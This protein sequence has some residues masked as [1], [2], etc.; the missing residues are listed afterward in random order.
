MRGQ[1]GRQVRS[2]TRELGLRSG[3][4]R[5]YRDYPKV[6]EEAFASNG[7]RELPRRP[8]VYSPEGRQPSIPGV[9]RSMRTSSWIAGLAAATLLP[10]LAQA[11][12]T[13]EQNHG[14][15][16]VGT[17]AGAGAGALLGSA[18]AGHDNRTAGGVIGGL[19]GALL[20]NQLTKPR[21]DC[22]HAYGYYD[23]NAKWH[24]SNT[25]A[26]DATGYFNQS[27][28]WVDGAPN[29]YFDRSG[30]WVAGSGA[31]SASGYRDPSGRWIPA[32]AGG[33]YDDSGHW[34]TDMAGGHYDAQGRWIAGP[35][36]GRYDSQGRWSADAQGGHRDSD[37]GSDNQTQAGD[38][39][40][41]GHWRAGQSQ[42]YYDADGHWAGTQRGSD[43]A[44]M[45]GHDGARRNF[46][47]RVS[48][49]NGRI[50]SDLNDG[51]LSRYDGAQAVRTLNA[52]RRQEAGMRHYNGR[53]NP[54]GERYIQARLD[55]LAA[56]L[57]GRG[58]DEPRL[59]D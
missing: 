55:T 32:S 45:S 26:G 33:Y 1:V 44:D 41:N 39:D 15:R 27:D 56:S 46:A 17:L 34:T 25:S 22:A 23:H 31:A 20:G 9:F 4:T 28:H 47:T 40:N 29:G 36:A 48:W 57:P 49:L 30:A 54:R 21:G 42:G 3:S 13:C 52:I 53:L 2:L 14:A 8:G 59:N 38:Y 58:V 19:G 6:A 10:A 37:G 7:E 18:I 5:A 16:V 51:S 11:Q 43:P 24:A 50:R 12:S 35:A